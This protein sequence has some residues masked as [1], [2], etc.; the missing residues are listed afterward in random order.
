MKRDASRVSPLVSL[1]AGLLN[2]ADGVLKRPATKG[3][4]NTGVSAG[5]L[6]LDRREGDAVAFVERLVTRHGLPV[7]ADQVVFGLRRVDLALEELIAQTS[8]LLSDYHVC[9]NDAALQKLLFDTYA[10]EGEVKACDAT[11][12]LCQGPTWLYTP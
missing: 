12:A 11:S 4:A 1:L 5:A 2:V 9:N 7:D 6:D 3:A 8:D 10:A